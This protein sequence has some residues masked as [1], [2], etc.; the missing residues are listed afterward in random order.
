MR[1]KNFSSSYFHCKWIKSL[2]SAFIWTKF[3]SRKLIHIPKKIHKIKTWFFLFKNILDIFRGIFRILENIS[4]CSMLLTIFA[5]GLHL[6]CL[7]GF[8][9]VISIRNTNDTF[10]LLSVGII[11]LSIEILH[12]KINIG[13]HDSCHRN[14]CTLI[15][16]KIHRKML[17]YL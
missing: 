2:V 8:W 11:G 5:E 14:I 6:W 17:L 13:I 15:L 12:E 16:H 7:T 10:R 3:C 1:I 9:K 4:S